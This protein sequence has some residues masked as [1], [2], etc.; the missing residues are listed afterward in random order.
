MNNSVNGEVAALE[1]RLRRTEAGLVA[2]AVVSVSFLGMAAVQ[3]ESRRGDTGPPGPV[4]ATRFDLVDAKDRVRGSWEIAEDGGDGSPILSLCDSGS[5]SRIAMSVVAGMPVV[6]INGAVREDKVMRERIL[7]SIGQ[8]GRPDIRLFDNEGTLRG[9][10][11]LGKEGDIFLD[12][13]DKQGGSVFR[14][15]TGR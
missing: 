14:A 12:L 2:V 15:P 4:K 3:Q 9:Q 10:I 7:L 5:S 8:D 1:R 11:S 13:R 6:A